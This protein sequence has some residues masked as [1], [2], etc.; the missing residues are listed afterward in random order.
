[1]YLVGESLGTGV[2][3]YLVGHYPEKISGI[4]LLAPYPCLAD[5]AQAHMKLLPIIQPPG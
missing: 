4:A 5:V 1:V 3:A 2:A